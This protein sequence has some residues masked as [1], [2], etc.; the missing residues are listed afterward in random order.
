MIDLP[1]APPQ[2]SPDLD[3]MR[4]QPMEPQEDPR[5]PFGIDDPFKEYF[6]RMPRFSQE[7]GAEIFA[8]AESWKHNVESNGQFRQRSCAADQCE[9]E[10]TQLGILA[11]QES[12]YCARQFDLLRAAT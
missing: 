5:A 4:L 2:F 9:P 7:V 10:P 3:Q 11:R 12:T 6:G 1:P 8:K